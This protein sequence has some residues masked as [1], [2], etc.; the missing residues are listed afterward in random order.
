MKFALVDN[1]KVEAFPKG[2]G[3]CL[4]CNAETIAKCG[5]KRI[6]HWAHKNINHCDNWWENETEWHRTWKSQFPVNWQEV[7]QFDNQTGEKHI[8]DVKTKNGFV[9]EF[10]NSPMSDQEMKSREDFYE[11]MV[12]VVN[13]EKFIKNFHILGSLPKPGLKKYSDIGFCST[14]KGYL[15]RSFFKYSENP[16]WEKSSRELILLRMYSFSEI[17]KEVEGD[18]IG[19]H[20]FDWIKPRTNWIS[21]KCDV[22][23]DFGG[24]VLWKL[25]TYDN[26]GLRC[27]RKI[28][29]KIFIT[30]AIG[31]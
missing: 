4:C 7:V 1:K 3:I 5:T 30:R 9:L 11:K 24:E 12:W 21:S 19:H 6:N 15:G 26:K 14:K 31:Q 27:V 16:N 10:Q 17:E 8:A 13:G 25:M 20:L 18:Y 23:I 2:K 29:K 28:D 22:F